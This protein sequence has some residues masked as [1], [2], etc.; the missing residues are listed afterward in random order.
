M[1]SAYARRSVVVYAEISRAMPDTRWLLWEIT[2]MVRMAMS[3]GEGV[4][5]NEQ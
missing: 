1:M 4:A 5:M 2:L 3:L